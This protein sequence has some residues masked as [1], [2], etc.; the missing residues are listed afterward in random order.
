MPDSNILKF[1]NQNTEEQ[2]TQRTSLKVE[3]NGVKIEMDVYGSDISGINNF[4]ES[5]LKTVS[6]NLPG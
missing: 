6:L 2:E 1:F 5:C 3:F 4:L